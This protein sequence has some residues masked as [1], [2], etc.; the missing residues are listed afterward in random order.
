MNC[1]EHQHHHLY[2]RKC[3]HDGKPVTHTL[4]SSSLTGVRPGHLG[5]Q[6][7][8]LFNQQGDVLQQ[9]FVL[10]QQL[11]DSSLRLQSGRGLRVQLVPQ[12][13]D[14]QE[15]MWSE[16]RREQSHQA[17]TGPFWNDRVDVGTCVAARHLGIFALSAALA[18][19]S[20]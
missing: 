5:L 3:I 16:D 7:L 4:Q 8:N 17:L 11:V 6:L 9:V 1:L 13:V 12:E 14:L 18:L 2:Y 15:R 20:R 10:Q 19:T